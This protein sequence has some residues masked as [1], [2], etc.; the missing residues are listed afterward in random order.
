MRYE[1]VVYRPP[2]EAN[3]LLIQATIGCPHNKCAFCA[4]YKD[5]TFR[6]RPVEEIKADLRVAQAQYGTNV[7]TVFFPDGNTIIMRTEQLEE[8]FRYT[9]QLFPHMERITLYGSTQ[10]INR[11]SKE[12]LERLKEAGLGRIHCG[13]ESGDDITLSRICKGADAAAVIA[14]GQKVRTA[15]IEL[16]EYILIGIGGRERTKEHAIASARVLNEIN[17]EFIRLRTF[18]PMA[19]T[20]MY[21]RWAAGEFGL[22]SPHEALHETELFITNLQATS[23]LYSDHAS[24]YAYVNG[25]IPEDKPVMLS[26]I[27]KLLAI[28]EESFRPPESGG[29]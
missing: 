4:M 19:G 1:G 29:L 10:F 25:R 23:L 9:R 22:L 5:K 16:S 14:A 24:N 20:V 21:E 18:I 15:G 26:T 28:P 7:D 12:E 17:P 8:I 11:K 13:I 3:S 27:H 6:I 2:S